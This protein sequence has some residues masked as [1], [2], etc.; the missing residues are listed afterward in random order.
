MWNIWYWAPWRVEWV[1]YCRCVLVCRIISEFKK[2][3][4]PPKPTGR[5]EIATKEN[6]VIRIYPKTGEMRITLARS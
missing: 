5:D 2:I 1:S 4:L 3:G 6:E